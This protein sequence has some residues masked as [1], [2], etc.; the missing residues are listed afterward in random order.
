MKDRQILG[1]LEVVEDSRPFPLIELTYSQL[2]VQRLINLVGATLVFLFIEEEEKKGTFVVK[3]VP[4]GTV[5]V[6]KVKT[7]NCRSDKTYQQETC[8]TSVKRRSNS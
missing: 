6:Q 2:L 5:L 7:F 8:S 4:L 3:V 1:V